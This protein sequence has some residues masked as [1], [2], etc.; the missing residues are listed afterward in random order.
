MKTSDPAG[1]V[2][3]LSIGSGEL[4]HFNAAKPLNESRSS[5]LWTHLP[6]TGST[7]ALLDKASTILFA[8]DLAARIPTSRGI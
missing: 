3:F 4:R 1:T 2:S 6:A 5:Q 8:C 7:E